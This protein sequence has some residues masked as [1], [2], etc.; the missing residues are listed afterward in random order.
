MFQGIKIPKVCK[1]YSRGG[2]TIGCTSTF[3]GHI[4]VTVIYSVLY[5]LCGSYH[6]RR[7]NEVILSNF[8]SDVFRGI[9]IPKVW[10]AYYGGGTTTG[11]TSTF[12]V[13]ITVKVLYWGLYKLCGWYHC[14]GFI[15]FILSNF[16]YFPRGSCAYDVFAIIAKIN[17]TNCCN[18][19]SSRQTRKHL[20]K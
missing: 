19:S 12:P 4:T 11:C 17:F 14:R 9:R 8:V 10:K 6:C 16:V 5:K 20:Q 15:E 7:F 2:T 1:A 3:P 18:L 13:H